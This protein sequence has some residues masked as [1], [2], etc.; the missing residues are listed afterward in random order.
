MKHFPLQDA[1]VVHLIYDLWIHVS[2]IQHVGVIGST[3]EQNANSNAQGL[4]FKNS[5]WFFKNIICRIVSVYVKAMLNWFLVELNRKLKELYF[6]I[7]R[8]RKKVTITSWPTFSWAIKLLS[9]LNIS[10]GWFDYV[11]WPSFFTTS[12]PTKWP[13]RLVLSLCSSAKAFWAYL[14]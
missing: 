13:T 11:L 7:R 10:D 8:L 5:C 9:F 12:G 6:R 14:L 4:T 3:S 1:N 2:K